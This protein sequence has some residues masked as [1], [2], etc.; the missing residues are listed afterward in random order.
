[1]KI[2]GSHKLDGL[3]QVGNWQTYIPVVK[4]LA[5][6]FAAVVAGTLAIAGF[7][8]WKAQLKGK[9]EYELASFPLNRSIFIQ[10]SALLQS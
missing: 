9:D 6:I 1:M 3:G 5:T 8:S 2:A 10:T 4:D 7:G